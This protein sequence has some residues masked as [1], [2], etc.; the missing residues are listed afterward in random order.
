MQPLRADEAQ[1]FVDAQGRDVVDF[2]LES[3]L[4]PRL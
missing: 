1:I 4:T 3:D 2:G